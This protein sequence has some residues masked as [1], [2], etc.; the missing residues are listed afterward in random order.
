[1]TGTNSDRRTF[2][3]ASGTALSIAVAGCIGGDDDGGSGDADAPAA[4]DDY[5]NENDASGYDGSVVD[6]TGSDSVSIDVGSGD[7]FAYSPVAVS[8][9]Q[10]TEVTWEWTGDGG[11]HNVVPADESDIDVTVEQEQIAQSGHTASHTF[12]ETGNYLYYC[13]PH[14]DV[15]MHAAVI[16]E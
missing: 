5:L 11:G 2:L 10:G 3:A 15:G 8:V 14:V 4:V 13:T 7:G 9:D 16:V 12:D 1:M 6:E